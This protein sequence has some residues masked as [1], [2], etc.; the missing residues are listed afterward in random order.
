MNV[1]AGQASQRGWYYGWNIVAFSI[2]STIAGNGLTVNAFSLFL[3][4]WSKA[5]NTNISTLQLSL[6]IM[7]LGSSILA[8]FVGALADKYPARWLFAIGLA[9]MAIYHVGLS[10]VDT[11]W[12][13]LC[14]RRA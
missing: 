1:I 13:F 6:A 5:L 8:P 3:K 11:T 9:G 14:C 7:G 4:D 2:L 10:F 12:Q